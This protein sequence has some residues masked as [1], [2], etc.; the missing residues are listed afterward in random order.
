MRK[1]SSQNN[2]L[3]ID[4]NKLKTNLH[5]LRAVSSYNLTHAMQHTPSLSGSV[6]FNRDSSRGPDSDLPPA[7]PV[8]KQW[9]WNAVNRARIWA[10]PHGCPARMKWQA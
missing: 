1:Q 9:S 5:T 8:L 3:Q 10:K 2:I 4:A 6:P 7:Y